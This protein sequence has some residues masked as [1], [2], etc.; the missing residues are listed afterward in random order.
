MP[1]RVSSG[2]TYSARI[3]SAPCVHVAPASLVRQTP[4][5]ET[6]IATCLGSRGSTQIEW[7]PASSLPPPPH[8]GRSGMNHS[9]SLIFHVAPRSSERNRP[10]GIVPHHSAPSLSSAGASDQIST[11]AHSVSYTHLT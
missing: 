7:M 5:I 6:P 4:A 11:V 3:P 10:P 8:F 9:A 2:G 1:A